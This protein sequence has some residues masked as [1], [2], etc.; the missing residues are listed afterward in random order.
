[1]RK[2]TGLCE[3]LDEHAKYMQGCAPGHAK[4]CKVC[5]QNKDTKARSCMQMYSCL[6]ENLNKPT[7]FL[8][9]SKGSKKYML[10]EHPC[11]KVEA[12][13]PPSNTQQHSYGEFYMRD[14]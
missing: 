3:D 10:N 7:R 12:H 4:K 5:Q 2:F 11:G 6:H 9:Y 8:V 14:S 1:M 13:I